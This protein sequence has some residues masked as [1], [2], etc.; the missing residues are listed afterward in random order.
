MSL[1]EGILRI[2]RKTKYATSTH[3]T[4]TRAS[5]PM[6]D[7][8]VSQLVTSS[9]PDSQVMT[10][11]LYSVV[12]HH[13]SQQGGHYTAYCL[14][15]TA[16][17]WFFT[18]D[19]NVR[20][21]TAAEVKDASPYIL[22]YAARVSVTADGRFSAETGHTKARRGA[23]QGPPEVLRELKQPV[24]PAKQL[25]AGN[26]T[27]EFPDS[28]TA[29]GTDADAIYSLARNSQS[30]L[31]HKPLL[32]QPESAPTHQQPDPVSPLEQPETTPTQQ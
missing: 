29:T 26:I 23:T 30:I 1:K 2:K 22:F 12:E 3:K 15:K 11:D 13:G 31:K 9:C 24:D 17:R 32:Q 28:A 16:G 6:H 10:Y 14:N 20:E 8:D 7:L 27:A 21:C 4:E 25:V 19:S 18:S 5:F